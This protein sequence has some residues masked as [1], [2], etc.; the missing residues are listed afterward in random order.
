MSEDKNDKPSLFG[1]PIVFTPGSEKPRGDMVM[2]SLN[3]ML[4]PTPLVDENDKPIQP[5]SQE[6]PNGG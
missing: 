3:D 1:F 6:D 2:G 4:P 5:E